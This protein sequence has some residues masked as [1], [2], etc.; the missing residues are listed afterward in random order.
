MIRKVLHQYLDSLIDSR[1]KSW[2]YDTASRYLVVCKIIRKAKISSPRI[3]DVGSSGLGL[4]IY[5]RFPSDL[6]VE[7]D[8]TFPIFRL[9]RHQIQAEVPPLP[10]QDQAFDTVTSLDM[11]EHI[12]PQSR[13]QVIAEMIRVTSKLFIL[14]VPTGDNAL[15]QDLRVAAKFREVRNET[16]DF[17][18]EHLRYGLPSE[19]EVIQWVDLSI[20]NLNRDAK[21]EVTPNANLRLRWAMMKAMIEQRWGIREKVA[22]LIMPIICRLTW[23]DC[24]RKLFVVSFH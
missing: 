2:N 7:L 15:R 1:R 14:G 9:S 24:Y 12:P 11:L 21:I 6:L 13:K 4:S 10:F 16:F 8:P 20:D 18:E 22:L 23:G 5:F 17:V 19:A 3:L